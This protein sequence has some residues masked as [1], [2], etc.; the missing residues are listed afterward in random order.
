MYDGVRLNPGFQRN[1]ISDKCQYSDDET[2]FESWKFQETRSSGFSVGTHFLEA[3]KVW[4]GPPWTSGGGL[5]AFWTTLNYKQL[6]QLHGSFGHP[7]AGFLCA[8]P[9]PVLGARRT[10]RDCWCRRWVGMR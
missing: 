1:K 4:P 3:P 2:W 7:L 8:A 9:R 10:H 5:G 6:Q